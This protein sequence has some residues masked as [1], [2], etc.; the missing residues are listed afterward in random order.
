MEHHAGHAGDRRIFGFKKVGSER[1][2]GCGMSVRRVPL[3]TVYLT[4]SAILAFHHRM[5]T[6]TQAVHNTAE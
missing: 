4:L 5:P 2:I 3:L 1:E 6:L